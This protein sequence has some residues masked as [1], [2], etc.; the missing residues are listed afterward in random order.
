[1]PLVFEWDAAKAVAN[2]RK[3]GVTFEEAATVFA[4]PLAKIFPDLDHSTSEERELVIGHS[5]QARL[6]VVSFT[7]RRTAIRLISARPATRHE[8]KDYEESVLLNQNR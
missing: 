1:M 4:D 8:R 5:S 2:V 7:E 3:H 6:L